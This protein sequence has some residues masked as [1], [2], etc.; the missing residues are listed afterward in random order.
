MA[1]ILEVLQA[2]RGAEVRLRVRVGDAP[3]DIGRALDN[4]VI[5]DDPH[6]D[7]VHA[8]LERDEA[9][10]LV[11]RDLDS[12]NGLLA[13]GRR[14]AAV[15]VA[16][17]TTV[18]LGRTVL[19]FRDPA[20]PVP[21]AVPLAPAPAA[22]PAA[23]WERPAGRAVVLAG[24]ALFALVDGWLGA[25]ER[26]A[27]AHTF[28]SV[29]ALAAVACV[30]AGIWA[31]TGRAVR[32]QFRYASHLAVVALGLVAYRL[33]AH[34]DA[35]GQFLLPA[36]T[37]FAPVQVGLWLFLL[38][39][40]VAGHLG[41]ATHLAPVQRWRA[42]TVASGIVLALVA[43]SALLEEERFTPAA[44]FSGVVRTLDPAL[45]PQQSL[46][47]WGATLADLRG[48]VDSLLAER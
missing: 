41:A 29:L 36:A 18:T 39:A 44:E 1:L 19:R 35:W 11:L 40:M 10:A 21:P 2:G 14:V 3:L 23:W 38:A 48:E 9:G 37:F 31:V 12:V 8:R 5:L 27:A 42:G 4:A 32:G 47:E 7:A 28:G 6:V 16:P 45:V 30:W 33:L 15:P 22:S 13:D 43:V 17:G 46:D 34:V 24:A 20:A 26:G 25:T